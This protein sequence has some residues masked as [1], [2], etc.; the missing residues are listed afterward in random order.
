MISPQS[1]AIAAAAGHLVG[2]ESELFRFTVKHSFIMLLFICFI[3]LAQAYLFSW[4][5]PHY[6]MLATTSV[7]A[8]TDNSKGIYY[9]LVLAMVLIAFAAVI[10][11]MTKKIQRIKNNSD[12]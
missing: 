7:G 5:I 8:A 9:L 3:V 2:R 4:I 12:N 10:I 6:Q 1:I 11:L